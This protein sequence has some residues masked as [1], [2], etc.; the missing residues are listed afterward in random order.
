MTSTK[1]ILIP[2]D[3]PPAQSTI[4]RQLLFF[5]SLLVPAPDDAAL[6][7]ENEV[8]E[9]FPDGYTL[10]WGELGPYPRSVSYDDSY[11]LLRANAEFA[12]RSGK[13]QFVRVGARSAKEATQNWM[14]AVAALKTESLVRAALLDHAPDAVPP[15]MNSN[16]G[17]N[18]VVPSRTGYES[19]YHWLTQ[20]D[21]QAAVPLDELWRRVAMGRLGRAMKIVR[22]AAAEGAIPLAADPTNRDI[23][24]ALGA[25]AYGD[26]PTPQH[27]SSA[28]LALDAV[29]PIA[30]D[31]AL[32]TMGWPEVLRIRKEV[33]PAVSKLRGLIVAAVRTALD[34]KMRPS[35]HISPL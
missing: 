35:S 29:D 5:D 20:V 23:C 18:M 14:A 31:A 32:D 21:S 19:Q 3:V 24:L 12:T 28:A 1:A 6:L 15:N 13:L 9:V 30:L 17:Y 16:A 26:L 27:L 25:Q 4:K 34:L 11:R 33:L 22:R 7:N 10:H 8:A 2:G